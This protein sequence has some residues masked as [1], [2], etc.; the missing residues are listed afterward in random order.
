MG[1]I[2]VSRHVSEMEVLLRSQAAT[3]RRREALAVLERWQWDEMVDHPS[4]LRARQ[5]VREFG[6]ASGREM[7]IGFWS[8]P[9][10][11]DPVRAASRP[12]PN[13]IATVVEPVPRTRVDDATHR[14]D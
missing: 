10:L 2:D 6:S 9:S 11:R 5:L 8:P 3:A 7:G 1:T 13:I 4:R 14:D 12:K